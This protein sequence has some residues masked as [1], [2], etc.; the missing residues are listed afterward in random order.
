MSPYAAA[1]PLPIAFIATL[2]LGCGAQWLLWGD[3]TSLS[4]LWTWPILWVL[5][6]LVGLTIGE[7]SKRLFR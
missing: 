5:Y 1:L 4:W 7:N 3:A 6:A 2:A